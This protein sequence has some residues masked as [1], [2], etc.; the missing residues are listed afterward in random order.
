[1]ATEAKTDSAML[2]NPGSSLRTLLIRE[3]W[4]E[5]ARIIIVA[6][7]ALLYAAEILPLGVLLI[8]IAFGLYP[9]V[10]TGVID[11]IRERKLALRLL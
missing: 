9:L 4:I 6:I 10:K 8:A 3:R 7:V 11:L 1:M 5:I 2:S